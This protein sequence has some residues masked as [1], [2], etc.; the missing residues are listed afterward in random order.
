MYSTRMVVR[1][2]SSQRSPILRSIPRWF[3]TV[4]FFADVPSADTALRREI[5][6]KC[7]RFTK[8]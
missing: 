7:N 1:L 3:K 5:A 4:R 2:C 8:S 6:E